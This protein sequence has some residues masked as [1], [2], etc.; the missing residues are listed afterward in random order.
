[1]NTISKGLGTVCL[2]RGIDLTSSVL[3]VAAY[4]LDDGVSH[5]VRLVTTDPQPGGCQVD[6][7]LS[8]EAAANLASAIYTLSRSA[9]MKR[10]HEEDA[11]SLQMTA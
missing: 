9:I 7:I 1:M 2:H 6:V 8:A 5:T 11:D 4:P 3:N 10:G